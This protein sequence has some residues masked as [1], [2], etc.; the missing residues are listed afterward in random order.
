METEV[1][2]LKGESVGKVELPAQV[3]GL[4]PCPHYLHEVSTIYLN[5]QRQGNAHTK[6]RGEISGGGRKPWRQKGTGRARAG[7]NRSPIWRKGGVV[8]GPR[9]RDYRLELP[10]HKA[11]LALAQALSARAQ[12]GSLRVVDG[13][14][15]DGAKTSQVAGVLKALKADSRSLI[16]AEQANANLARASRNIPG[17]KIMLV[18][19]LNAYAV[20][21]C[22]NLI[23]TRGALEKLGPKWN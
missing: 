2:N 7:S 22:R 5:N 8:F 13:L 12:D 3:F 4:K 17:L 1:L 21:A 15:I 23:I 11:K 9:T 6:T 19:H 20:L 18:A 10:R 16:V 14:A